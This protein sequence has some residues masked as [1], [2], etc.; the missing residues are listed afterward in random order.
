[1]AVTAEVSRDMAGVVL[2]GAVLAGGGWC[3]PGAGA[4]RA[5]SRPLVSAATVNLA[6]A[7]PAV[8]GCSFFGPIRGA[9][10]VADN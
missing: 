6:R 9:D 10:G 2:A 8:M 4:A 1:M 5:A 3:T 7:G